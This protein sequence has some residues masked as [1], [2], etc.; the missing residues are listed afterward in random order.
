MP[1]GGELTII[2]REKDGFLELEVADTG[3][4]I[5][6]EIR[7]KIFDPLFTT[8][9][10]GIGLGLAVC[11]SIIERHQGNIEVES[12][13]GKGTTFRIKLPLKQPS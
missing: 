12:Q 4:G 1:D 11:K 6:E 7:D 10:K 5:P 13:L 3:S 2:A 9:A 8:R